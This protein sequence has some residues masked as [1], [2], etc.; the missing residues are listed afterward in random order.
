MRNGAKRHWLPILL[1]GLQVFIGTG[2]VPAGLIF[3]LDP[4]GGGLGFSPE[5]L[6][7]TFLRNYLI[8]G[9]VLLGVNGLGSL[10]GGALSFRR[11]RY[12]GAVGIVLGAL[13]IAWIVTQVAMIGLV[14]WLQPLYFGL[15]VV[16]V[17]LALLVRRRLPGSV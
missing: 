11:H 8:P 14:H 15:G 6:E 5:L 4:S 10:L 13:L 17:I 1:G 12:T 3:I 7:G 9:L 2:D 16:E